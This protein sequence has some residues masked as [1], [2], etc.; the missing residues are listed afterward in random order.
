MAL[1]TDDPTQIEAAQQLRLRFGETKAEVE[2]RNQFMAN[3]LAAL[4]T[5]RPE[6]EAQ[7]A[8]FRA[9]T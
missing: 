8:S 7:V 1:A 9:R 3:V 5:P 2:G 6:A 4:G